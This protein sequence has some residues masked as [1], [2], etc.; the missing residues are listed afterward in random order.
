MQV[1][2]S[3]KDTISDNFQ[4]LNLNFPPESSGPRDSEIV[5]MN[6]DFVSELC[7]SNAGT[8]PVKPMV[9]EQSTKEQT[10]NNSDVPSPVLSSS[11]ATYPMIEQ[12]VVVPVFRPPTL[13]SSA[14]YPIIDQG[15]SAPAFPQTPSSSVSYPIIDLS[16]ASIAGPSEVTAPAICRQ[17]PPPAICVQ[18]P[19][20]AISVQAPSEED[21]ENAVEQS[22]LKEL[23]DMGFK[24]VDLNKEI[25]RMN[26]FDLEKSVDDLCG[27]AEWDPILEELQEMVNRLQKLWSFFFSWFFLLLIIEDYDIGCCVVAGFL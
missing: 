18:A 8:G 19:S 26:E 23:E 13:S 12:G 6:L 2:A 27:A 7:N 15:V 20:T 17:A 3:L 1:D 10:V 11:S 4:G 9:Y 21:S 16:E 5:D 25:L 24:Q 14:A 22:L